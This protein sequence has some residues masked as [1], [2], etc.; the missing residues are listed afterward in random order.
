V[1]QDV[2]WWSDHQRTI[3]RTPCATLT[4]SYPVP[5]TDV[6]TR[7]IA[8]LADTIVPTVKVEQH[9][10]RRLWQGLRTIT[11][12]RGR[13]PLTVSADASQVD[14]LNSFYALFKA[15]NNTVSVTVAEVSSIAR[16]EHTL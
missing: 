11:D 12:Y 6:V 8:T 5:V 2:K 10:T 3:F 1:T 13:T 14:D 7:F 4:C 9:D 15:S 16:D